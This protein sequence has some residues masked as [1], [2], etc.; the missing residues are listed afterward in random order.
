MVFRFM[1]KNKTKQ[2]SNNTKLINNFS[3]IE[4]DIDVSIS[5]YTPDVRDMF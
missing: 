3:S 2:Y 5:H 1:V 4:R